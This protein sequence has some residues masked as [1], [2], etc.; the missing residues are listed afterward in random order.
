GDH[1]ERMLSQITM[2]IENGTV[3]THGPSGEDQ[4]WTVYL[5]IRA[6]KSAAL[7]L[8]TMNGPISLYDVDGKLTAHA[9]NGPISLHNVSGDADVTAQN[10]PISLDGSSGNIRIRTENG[11]ISVNVN[12]TSWNGSELSAAAQNGAVALHVPSGLQINFAACC[13]KHASPIM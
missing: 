12:G 8:E 13:W 6:P 7:E 3:S 11:P 10:G 9:N 4:D 5:L 2:S 1:D